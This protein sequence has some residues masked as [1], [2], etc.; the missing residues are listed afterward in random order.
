[1]RGVERIGKESRGR[2]IGRSKKR[3]SG[4]ISWEEEGKERKDEDVELEGKI[5]VDFGECN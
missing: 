1:V 4:R 3:R 2:K 5:R